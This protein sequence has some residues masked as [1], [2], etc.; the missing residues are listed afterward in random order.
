MAHVDD[1]QLPSAAH[2]TTPAGK[3]G[4]RHGEKAFVASNG[5]VAV[6]MSSLVSR[7]IFFDVSRKR[8]NRSL[9]TPKIF[10]YRVGAKSE[11]NKKNIA[12]LSDI[13][14]DE[15]AKRQKKK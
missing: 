5:G 10:I 12:F 6:S 1:E 11:N 9:A 2:L 8:T 7:L 13:K 3:A 4:Y 14:R 15:R